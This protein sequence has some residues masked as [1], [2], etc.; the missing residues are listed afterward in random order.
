MLLFIINLNGIRQFKNASS[1]LSHHHW[2]SISPT[3]SMFQLFTSVLEGFKMFF[4]SKIKKGRVGKKGLLP[5]PRNQKKRKVPQQNPWLSKC[6]YISFEI[7]IR[8]CLPLKNW[9]LFT[10]LIKRSSKKN[11]RRC[12]VSRSRGFICKRGWKKAPC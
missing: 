1:R 10:V 6:V 4:V 7:F 11:L 9:D 3:S 8:S 2:T 12:M 5:D